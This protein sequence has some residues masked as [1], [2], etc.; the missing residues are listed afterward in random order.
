LTIPLKKRRSEAGQASL[1]LLLA[2]S[3]FLLGALGFAIDGSHLYAQRQMAQ[4]A[5]DAAAQAGI[6]SIFDGTNTSVPHAFSTTATITCNTS[7][8]KTP[9]Y[10]AQT[11][12][13]FNGTN[14]TITV[15][16]PSAADVG[17]S[18]SSLS[19]LDPVNLLRVTVSRQ[20]NTTFIRLLGP[21]FESVRASGT[22]AI[23]GIMSPIPIIVMHPSASGAFSTNGGSSGDAIAIQGGPGRSIQVNSSSS[24]SISV[25]GGATINLSQAGPLVN[26]VASGGY[27]GDLGGPSSYPSVIPSGHYIQPASPIQDPFANVA[28]PTAPANAP[29]PVSLNNGSTPTMWG[30]PA[31]TSCQHY[32]PGT[33]PGGIN[34]SGYALFEP[35]LY[36]ITS[37]GFNLNSNTAA[38]MVPSTC[39]PP[40]CTTPPSDFATRRGMLVFNSG[41][42]KDD[43]VNFSS[44]AGTYGPS[45]G[46]LGINL[47]GSDEAGAYQGILF[48]QDRTSSA[49]NGV[50]AFKTHSIT[51]GATM[52]LTG[53]IYFTNTVATMTTDATHFQG[54]SVQ[55]NGSSATT[56]IGEIIADELSVGGTSGVS[57]TLSPSTIRVV[58][59]VALVQ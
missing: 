6:M 33:Y 39:T 27:F 3:I 4:A 12:N 52:S 10:Y 14:D 29:L 44:N 28:Q 51:G 11:L 48:F 57:M 43:I 35:G 8:A 34:V 59:Q 20:V 53:T 42:A 19:S 2:M 32:F 26:G 45:A 21:S 30:C 22:A 9:C 49:H 7:D 1:L 54:L 58:R 41:N 46:P 25:S 5:A 13:G 37:G 17:V 36:Y 23:L 24:S 50:G 47:V 56:I 16:F 18:T 15:D 38:A 31:K 40:T 55:G